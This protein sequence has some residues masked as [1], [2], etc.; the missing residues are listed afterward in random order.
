M[1]TPL[2]VNISLIH[3]RLLS[4][5][6]LLDPVIQEASAGPPTTGGPQPALASTFRRDLWPSREVAATSFGNSKF[7]QAWDDRVLKKW[8]EFGLRDLP[9]AIYPDVS[10]SQDGQTGV[11]LTT[12]KHQEVFTFARPNYGGR[13]ATGKHVINRTTHA[14]YDPA[15]PSAY[16]FYR[17]EPSATFRNL[18][19]LR[20]SVLYVFGGESN[21]STPEWRKRKTESTG[22]GLG[23]SGGAPDGRVKEVVLEGIGHLVAMEAV[24]ACA[25]AAAMWFDQEVKRW[26]KEEEEF[27]KKWRNKK[28]QEKSMVDDEWMKRI[29][30]K[31]RR[32]N[33]QTANKL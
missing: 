12:P 3:P 29:G 14:D 33:A 13:D 22:T 16:P 27:Q 26:R 31:P 18:P 24:G 9:T 30:V 32:P 19:F 10:T 4:T 7:Y 1:L 8:I 25:E 6:V 28:K 21:M 5:L 11:T 2:R 20:P 23:G 17:P 15:D